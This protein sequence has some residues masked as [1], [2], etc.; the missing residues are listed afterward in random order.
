MGI[1][2]DRHQA[3]PS[4]LDEPNNVPDLK[5]FSENLGRGISL[6]FTSQVDSIVLDEEYIDLMLYKYVAPDSQYLARSKYYVDKDLPGILPLDTLRNAPIFAAAPNMR[7]V[8]YFFVL[9]F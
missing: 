2:L 5:L 7:Y 6:E 3:H 8:V 9:I 4:F 1:S